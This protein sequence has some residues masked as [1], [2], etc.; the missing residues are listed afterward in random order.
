MNTLELAVID[1]YVFGRPHP[2][3][4]ETQRNGTSRIWAEFLTEKQLRERKFRDTH[5]PFN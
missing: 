4:Q 5:S 3:Q 2:L 1:S